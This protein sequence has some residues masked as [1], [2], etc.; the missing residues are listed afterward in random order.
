[1]IIELLDKIAGVLV[2]ICFLLAVVAAIGAAR[3]WYLHI[4]D[5]Q[6]NGENGNNKQ[7]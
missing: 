1:M 6:T 5:N 2:I 3:E 7:V 4:K